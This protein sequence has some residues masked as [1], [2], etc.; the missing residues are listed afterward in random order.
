MRVREIH[1]SACSKTQTLFGD[2]GDFC[3]SFSAPTAG[4]CLFVSGF[5]HFLYETD[6]TEE[7]RLLTFLS[8]VV[9]RFTS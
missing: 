4:P 2:F 7:S 8:F 9:I 1:R 5:D 3:V 6:F